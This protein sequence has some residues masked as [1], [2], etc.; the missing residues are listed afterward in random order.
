M[1]VVFLAEI[2]LCHIFLVVLHLLFFVLLSVTVWFVAQM[3]QHLGGSLT[4]EKQPPVQSSARRL[5][6]SRGSI[7]HMEICTIQL[8]AINSSKVV[9]GKM[10]NFTAYMLDASSNVCPESPP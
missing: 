1:A 3:P 9:V 2:N 5:S 8:L 10:G 4:L 6:L 7:I